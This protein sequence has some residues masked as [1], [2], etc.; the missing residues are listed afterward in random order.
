MAKRDEKN[1]KDILAGWNAFEKGKVEYEKGV[2]EYKDAKE[3]QKKLLLKLKRSWNKPKDIEEA[4]KEIDDI[5][6]PKVYVL[7][8]NHN[9]GYTAFENDSSIVEGIARVLPFFFFM[10]AVLVCNHYVQNG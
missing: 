7:N 1:K 3:R 9:V 4:W 5:P 2:A 6:I 8:R 10:V